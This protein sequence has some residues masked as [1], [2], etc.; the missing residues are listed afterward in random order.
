MYILSLKRDDRIW[1]QLTEHFLAFPVFMFG[2]S[3]VFRG[4]L[5]IVQEQDC[6]EVNLKCDW[7]KSDEVRLFFFC[8]ESIIESFL[9][10]FDNFY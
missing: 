10:S 9:S 4:D 1:V 6:Y 7:R 5:G 2:Y 3:R 8:R